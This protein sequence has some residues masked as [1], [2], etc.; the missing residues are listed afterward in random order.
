MERRTHPADGAPHGR[1]DG[2]RD[3]RRATVPVGLHGSTRMMPRGALLRQDERRRC[4][5]Q[6][7]CAQ[8]PSPKQPWAPQNGRNSPPGPAVTR[9][10]VTPGLCPARSGVL[11]SR[12][13]SGGRLNPAGTQPAQAAS[14]LRTPASPCPGSV[15]PLRARGQLLRPGATPRCWQCPQEPP[16]SPQCLC[17]QGLPVPILTA[18]LPQLFPTP[19]GGRYRYREPQ[20]CHPRAAGAPGGLWEPLPARPPRARLEEAKQQQIQGILMPGRRWGAVPNPPGRSKDSASRRVRTVC[21]GK[22][23]NKRALPQGSSKRFF[24]F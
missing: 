11:G 3:G 17:S 18:M 21:R 12:V 16:A 6:R 19:R 23:K 8:P 10:S 14:P 22:K 2:R 4:P 1:T 7:C 5:Q 20:P 9:G 13:G 24:L 15:P